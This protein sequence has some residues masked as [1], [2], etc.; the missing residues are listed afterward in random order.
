MRRWLADSLATLSLPLGIIHSGTSTDSPKF[1]DWRIV[2]K[3]RTKLNRMEFGQIIRRKARQSPLR[4]ETSKCVGML[5]SKLSPDRIPNA[6][7]TEWQ[8]WWELLELHFPRP[9]WQAILW[10]RSS[11]DKLPS[12]RPCLVMPWVMLDAHSSVYH[13]QLR[14]IKEQ[15]F[16]NVRKNQKMLN[17]ID[18]ITRLAVEG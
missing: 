13:E 18:V 7:R 6:S 11:D 5:S 10:R 2:R 1:N 9:T 3:I 17:D 8:P 4:F 12:Q 16:S 15:A 14:V